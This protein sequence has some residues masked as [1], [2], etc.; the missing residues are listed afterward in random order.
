MQHVL[1][2][3]NGESRKNL[4]IKNFTQDTII[5]CN[6]LHRDIIVDH[7]VC[8]DRRMV[9]EALENPQTKNTKIYV[10]HHWYHFFRKIQKNKN[11]NHLPQIPY[12]GEYKRDDPEHWGSG[13]YAVLLAATLG[14][15]NIEMIGFDLYSIDHSV[16]NIYKNSSNYSRENS[17]PV[18]PCY[19]IYQI[20]Q[21]FKY[22]PDSKFILRN[23]SAWQM[24]KEWIKN[25]VEFIAL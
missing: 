16:N 15:P 25:N 19:W 13:P 10:R 7:L 3:G 18:D 8:C 1:V 24:P 2:V 21:I 12:Q 11:I 9:A 23:H 20:S 5:G 17:Q 22:Y 4:N 6:A 14:F